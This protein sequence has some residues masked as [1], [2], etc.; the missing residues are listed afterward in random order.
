MAGVP[1]TKQGLEKL[2]ADLQG[3]EERRPHMLKAV[4]E[5]REKGDL[6]ENAEYHAAREDLASME[7]RIAD[8]KAKIAMATLIDP[9]KVGGDTIVFGATVKLKDLA[10]DAE[11]EYKLVGEGEA[12]PLAN[13]ILTN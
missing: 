4:Q 2:K 11:E 8:L 9:S 7:G 10:D 12:D 6:R 13:R 1:M 5:A 3:L